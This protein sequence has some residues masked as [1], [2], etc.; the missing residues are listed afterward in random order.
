MLQVIK[1]SIVSENHLSHRS[2]EK[3]VEK[4]HFEENHETLHLNL[5]GDFFVHNRLL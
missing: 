3:A 2:A 5:F 1:K 4:S